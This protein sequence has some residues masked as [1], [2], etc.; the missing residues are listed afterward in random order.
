MGRPW[1]RKDGAILVVAAS[2]AIAGDPCRLLAGVLR[3]QSFRSPSSLQPIDD[4]FPT[5]L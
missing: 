2:P 1:P 5:I 3:P 4:T